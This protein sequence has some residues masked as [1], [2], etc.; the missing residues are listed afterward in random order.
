[1]ERLIIGTATST[2]IIGISSY[3]LGLI[4][5]HVKYHGIIIPAALI[6]IG[7]LSLLRRQA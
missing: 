6:S 3:Y 7:V 1:L 5:L 4:G 2:A